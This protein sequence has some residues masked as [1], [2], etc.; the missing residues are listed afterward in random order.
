MILRYANQA[1]LFVM[2]ITYIPL[3]KANAEAISVEKNVGR[4]P[5]KLFFS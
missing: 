2:S 3:K 1:I 4:G 5:V